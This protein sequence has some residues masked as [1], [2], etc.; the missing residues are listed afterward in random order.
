MLDLVAKHPT[1]TVGLGTPAL[2][3]VGYL[4]R[5]WR[6]SKRTVR[7]AL[8]ALLEIW[9]RLSVFYRT[10][11][12]DFFEKV[13]REIQRQIPDAA[14]ADDQREAVRQHYSPVL[15]RHLQQQAL[16][17]LESFESQF[18]DAVSSL[19]AD[20]P[21]LAYRVNAATK[22]RK[23]LRFLE[24]YLDEAL[25]PLATESEDGR[26]AADALRFE[27]EAFAPIDRL[28][29]LEKDLRALAWRVGPVSYLRVR[30]LIPRRRKIVQ[31]ISNEE[32]EAMVTNILLP[33]LHRLNK[34]M[35]SAAGSGG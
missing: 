19:S 10:D 9:H 34:Q 11:F 32:I 28:G 22:T 13:F 14:L 16:S 4:F 2:L 26:A 12:D 25:R 30:R 24:S 6:E 17:D 15:E 7:Y 18:A 35:Q 3:A 29:D 33:A 20:A 31:E 1:L 5:V 21:I 23:F 27:L 8:Y